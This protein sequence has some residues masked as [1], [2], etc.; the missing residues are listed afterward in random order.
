M[1]T[2]LTAVRSGVCK[3]AVALLAALCI[4]TVAA[5]GQDEVTDAGTLP[6]A[7]PS[8]TTPASP[9]PS[10]TPTPTPTLTIDVG[11]VPPPPEAVLTAEYGGPTTIS[12][13]CVDVQADATVDGDTLSATLDEAFSVMGI[14]V[15]TSDCDLTFQVSGLTG[16]TFGVDYSDPDN[17]G[18]SQTC[19]TESTLA[20]QVVVDVAGQQWSWMVDHRHEPGMLIADCPGPDQPLDIYMMGEA[21]TQLPALFGAVGEVAQAA[22]FVFNQPL[23][24]EMLDVLPG[25]LYHGSIDDHC[26]AAEAV[27]NS[28]STPEEWREL[29]PYLIHALNEEEKDPPQYGCGAL[30]FLLDEASGLNWASA[31]DYLEWWLATPE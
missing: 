19:Y 25:V 17:P 29:T 4:V 12:T 18:G 6:S 15:V 11:P 30:R 9:S 13:A 24:A 8:A 20:G 27:M 14:E 2:A 26:G 23:T 22:F 16:Q 28:Q 5:C 10:A 1:T 21:L 3:G 7:S 31:E